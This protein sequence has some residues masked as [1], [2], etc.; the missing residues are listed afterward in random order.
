M[1]TQQLR[2]VF[3]ITKLLL[4]LSPSFIEG[5]IA[6]EFTGTP[7]MG[8]APLNVVFT[9]S[10]SQA[11]NLSYSWD[12]G[13]GSTSTAENPQTTYLT[14]GE[15]TVK[16]TITDEISSYSTT[17]EAYIKVGEKPTAY[18]T[19]DGL[20]VDCAPFSTTFKNESSDTSGSNLIYTWSFG[21]GEG[22]ADEEP[23]HIYTSAGIYNVTLVTENLYCQD[24]YTLNQTIEAV[25]PQAVFGVSS[26]E[27]CSGQLNAV[28]SNLSNARSNFS[29]H[30][31]FGEGSTS[32]DK[33]PTH[34]YTQPGEYSVQLKV[35]DDLGCTDSVKHNNLIKITEI[36]SDFQASTTKGCVNE[37][38]KF[39]NLSKNASNYLWHFDDGTSSTQANP[40]K[41]YTQPGNYTVKL[42]A[43]GGS[44]T[45]EKE[46]LI[47]IEEA[48][49]QFTVSDNYIC[50]LPSSITY[51]N[52]SESAV[53]YDWRFGN[54]QVSNQ[55]SPTILYDETTKLNNYQAVYSDTLYVTSANG[56][57]SKYIKKNSVKIHLPN[58]QMSPG[59]AGS[60]TSLNGCIPMNLTF[61][62]KTI[63]NSDV[64]KVASYQWRI[65]G[66]DPRTGSST[67]FI[68]TKA[69]RAPVEL[70]VTTEK[71]C[72]SQAVE[73][74]NA[75]DKY[76]VDFERTSNYENCAD[77][78]IGF[79]INA[80]N[81]KNIT[82]EIW[83][84]GDDSE[85]GFPIPAHHY[86]KTG[87]MDV[88]LTI[89]NYG[90]ASKLT[91]K[92]YVKILGP[93]ASFE[94][95]RN[96]DDPFRVQFISNIQDA[97]TYS[98]DFGDGSP[99]VHN[100]KDPVHTY[101]QTGNYTVRL[102][103]FNS[104]TGCDFTV[105]EDVHIR[106]LISDFVV[107]SEA[108]CLN[109][110]LTLDG[111]SS[112][113]TSPFS[114]KGS[115][116]EYLWIFEEENVT[117]GSL[118]T[119]QHKFTHKGLNHVSLVVKDANGC[120][121]TLTRE[122]MIHQPEPNFI[123][124]HEVGCMPITFS[125]KNQ[126]N[127]TSPIATY[128]WNFGDGSSD[129]SQNPTHEYS[130]FGQ[131]TVSLK[132]T[133]QL[134]CSNSLKREEM[135]RAV[136][137]KATFVA[138]KHQLCTDD[139]AIF[140]ATSKNE[141]VDYF[142]TFANGVT[143]TSPNPEVKFSTPGY[144]S[145][146][147][148]IVDIHGCEANG[149]MNSYIDVQEPPKTEF[150][151]DITTANCYPFIVQFKNDT[152]T[153]YPGTWQ[154]D[155]GESRNQ[156]KLKDPFFIYNRPG[157]HDV[158]L[159]SRT[160]YGCTDTLVKKA[161]IHIDGPYA[162]FH[163][164]D[165]V[166]LNEDVQFQAISLDKV[167][168][169]HWDFGDGYGEP[170]NNQTHSYSTAGNK[171]PVL[172]LRTDAENTCNVAVVDT[173]HVLDLKAIIGF[174]DDISEYC[175]PS[176]VQ[177]KNNSKNS[178]S[179]LWQLDNQITSTDKEP[180]WTYEKEGKYPI[181]L[182]AKHDG[183]GCVHTTT[184][185]NLTIHPLP[186]VN[187]SSDT[188]ICVNSSATLWASG[189]IDYQWWPTEDLSSPNANS[190]LAKPNNNQWFQVTVTDKNG[191]INYGATN[192]Y[193]QQ[194]PFVHIPDTTLI[195]GEKIKVN[196]ENPAISAYRWSPNSQ[197]SC[198]DCPSPTIHALETTLYHVMVTDTS[199]CFTLSYPFQL[200]VRKV[201]SVD[202]P[203]AFTPN[204]DG[205]NDIVYVQGWGIKELITFKVYNRSGRMIFESNNIEKGWDGAY[206]GI[207]QPNE[208]YTYLVQVKTYDNKILSK[209]GAIKLLR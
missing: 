109:N 56:C 155:F 168:D 207:E 123:A 39:T 78:L 53:S 133:D 71:G 72:V 49:A 28:F 157:N 152:E 9:N 119:L 181:T 198:N 126:T 85:P 16:L 180:L 138:D 41:K 44:C 191:C 184:F 2:F 121:D 105:I 182:T 137:P 30:W 37:K 76:E 96:C 190:T 141:I 88:T 142:W 100:V 183:L 19:Y 161:Y 192:V 194:K 95:T 7:A 61:Q 31:S 17:K 187:L 55:K 26:N 154:W 34:L 131:Y 33:N 156:S 14:A 115:T 38:I 18:F 42:I 27:S 209:T 114:Y 23:E 188:V 91:R 122:I 99:K 172:F 80:P 128:E 201:Y 43:K 127:S 149:T 94:K 145:V 22:S 151:S 195:V 120:T 160:T 146:S 169:M 143:S 162:E 125:F 204:G 102:T 153:D 110:T 112:Q 173:L 117:I 175:V 158:K 67:N 24:S 10:S 8:C 35:T 132:V 206:K 101:A 81:R 177:F 111:N 51:I 62:D 108:P 36:E 13:N 202:L 147:L 163:L 167:F 20:T 150:S 98:W 66:E 205:I 5:Q 93:H 97:T 171:N 136:E 159:I 106:N 45:A 77:K 65:N 200:N 82:N 63:Y 12:F 6:V 178:T 124:S 118:K 140:S 139:S 52:Q 3:I 203:D 21:D 29:S 90:C 60:A 59:K 104:A 4:L 47:H 75:G 89:Y 86:E 107:P 83:D 185:S 134:G 84:F 50:Q 40:E 144:H 11:P 73:Y 74:I 179:W 15:F 116:V 189:G 164:P 46:M 92:N 69:Q 174:Q 58:V 57:K 186:N 79:K 64:D 54:G 199:Q 176:E 166:C 32:Q 103:A 148:K 165:S 48:V 70:T 25:K 130:S 129:N 87:P 170:N 1:I 196:I 68:V 135:I 113:D 208:T 197:L 193:V